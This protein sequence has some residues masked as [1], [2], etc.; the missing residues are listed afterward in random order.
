MFSSFPLILFSL[1]ILRK[2]ANVSELSSTDICLLFRCLFQKQKEQKYP[3]KPCHA[4]N[5]CFLC[6]FSHCVCLFHSDLFP[7]TSVLLLV[8][9]IA[10][11]SS[12][13]CLEQFLYISMAHQFILLTLLHFR[14]HLT[15]YLFSYLAYIS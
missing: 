1:I 9:R 14:F 13:C 2:G 6:C 5:L 7:V 10:S 15:T 8:G 12:S 11:S 4:L 3:T